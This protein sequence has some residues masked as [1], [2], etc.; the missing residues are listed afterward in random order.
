MAA[1]YIEGNDLYMGIIN[2]AF[3]IVSNSKGAVFRRPVRH[4]LVDIEDSIHHDISLVVSCVG[5]SLDENTIREAVAKNYEVKA[6]DVAFER[7]SKQ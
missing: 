3:I 4:N 6:K 7:V 2:S 1:I 5:C